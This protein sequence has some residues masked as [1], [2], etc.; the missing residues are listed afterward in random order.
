MEM[1]TTP[2]IKITQ[3]LSTQ[4]FRRL[5]FTYAVLAFL[6]KYFPEFLNKLIALRKMRVI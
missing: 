1:L 5:M 3:M 2:K 6:P 4:I